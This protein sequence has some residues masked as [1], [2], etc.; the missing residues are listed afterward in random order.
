MPSVTYYANDHCR[1]AN[2]LTYA[3][4][5]RRGLF[6]AGNRWP[7]GTRL[8]LTSRGGRRVVVTVAD[9]IGHGSDCDLSEPAARALMGSRYRIIGRVHAR[10]H[11]LH[12]ERRG[13][14]K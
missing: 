4:N 13:H 12:L 11:V 8:E 7:L 9:R 10:I 1:A 2:G 14:R 5:A 3:A 6:C